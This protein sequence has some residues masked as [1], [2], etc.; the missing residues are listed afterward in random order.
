MNEWH[1]LWSSLCFI[2]RYL[3]GVFLKYSFLMSFI[4][5]LSSFPPSSFCDFHSFILN[6]ESWLL[7]TLIAHLS[8]FSSCAFKI[9]LFFFSDFFFFREHFLKGLRW[10]SFQ[11]FFWLSPLTWIGSIGVVSALCQH[12]DYP[13]QCVTSMGPVQAAPPYEFF[14]PMRPLDA[15]SIIL[16]AVKLWEST[17]SGRL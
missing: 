3:S 17:V 11:L 15:P 4:V 9:Q 6:S 1:F 16:C 5:S 2:Q 7:L 8:T 10:C 13:S 12:P 14:W